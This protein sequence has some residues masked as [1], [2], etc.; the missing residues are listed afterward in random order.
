MKK[1]LGIL[2]ILSCLSVLFL[3]GFGNEKIKAATE[4]DEPEINIFQSVSIAKYDSKTKK[5]SD[6]LKDGDTVSY[7][8]LF[9]LEYHV[10]IPAESYKEADQ[11]QNF[12]IE[13]PE[14]VPVTMSEAQ[15]VKNE[16]GENL[17]SWKIINDLDGKRKLTFKINVKLA[18]SDE[19]DFH[20]RFYASLDK[21]EIEN[22]DQYL[23][24]DFKTLKDSLLGLNIT[25]HD[26]SLNEVVTD[27]KEA[28]FSSLKDQSLN[29]IINGRIDETNV[30]KSSDTYA[31]LVNA[32][33]KNN[34]VKLVDA[35]FVLYDLNNLEQ[36]A[37][38]IE[39][40]TGGLVIFRDLPEGSYRVVGSIS[41]DETY[42]LPET[43]YLDIDIP[44]DEPELTFEYSEGWG[45]VRLYKQNKETKQP[46]NGAE[47]KLVKEGKKGTEIIRE[48]LKTNED[49]V[50]Q[51]ERLFKG[52][53]A[54]IETKA[55]EGYVL[56]STPVRVKLEGRGT[57]SFPDINIPMKWKTMNQA[58]F[59][60]EKMKVTMDSTKLPDNL[61]FG[62]HKI[63]YKQDET[64]TAS[65]SNN[66]QTEGE[67]TI[68]DTRDSGGWTLKVKQ[69]S[70][71]QHTDSTNLSD[72]TSLTIDIGTVTNSNSKLPNNIMQ[73]VSLQPNDEKKIAMAQANEG[74][75]KTIIPL[76]KF[77]LTVPKNSSK[78]VGQ[79]DSSL[80]WT[81]SD[82]P[83]G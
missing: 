58:T 2:A 50:I 51:I 40:S 81:L 13:I 4:K 68:N 69:D 43:N 1:K 74:S 82:V 62:S 38:Q 27:K 63:Q 3:Y 41:A 48:N 16:Q 21:T 75:G 12:S 76:E 36:G 52:S 8:E 19:Q 9:Q 6:S 64:Y 54:F 56:D 24:I 44:S 37:I 15:P 14:F 39:D 45:G 29:R 67:I 78:K 7:D 20:I 70:E 22:K 55:P 60:N 83:E 32:R 28:D 18:E 57:L 77:S 65:D 42:Y 66:T 10:V 23:K 35:M 26:V 61:N 49:G 11:P 59:G 79:Y 31:I 33:D 25:N 30:D 72:N 34:S 5:V 46:L 71:F 73:S 17:G 53:Y 80:T 47:F